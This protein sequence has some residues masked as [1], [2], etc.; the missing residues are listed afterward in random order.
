MQAYERAAEKP[1]VHRE[2][3]QTV[4]QIMSAP[5]VTVSGEM[6]VTEASTLCHR[7]AFRHLPVQ[8]SG[9]ALV[10]MVSDRDL[11]GVQHLAPR[12]LVRDV[13]TREV[14]T[15]LTTTPVRSAAG[16]MVDEGIS[17]LPVIDDGH[18][19]VGIV[20]TSDLLRCIVNDGPLDLW[21]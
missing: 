2:V 19:L 1:K 6:P 8:G 20:T 17:A 16:V 12:R 18:V 9:G 15:A 10:G 4:S 13:M 3:V 21:I 11:L 7:H 14:L 5:V